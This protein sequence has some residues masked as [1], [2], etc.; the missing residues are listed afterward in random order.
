MKM[1]DSDTIIL[2]P[3]L[4]EESSPLSSFVILTVDNEI[5]SNGTILTVQNEDDSQ[6]LN[7]KSKCNICGIYMKQ[8]RYL[9]SH[10]RE[11]H[12]LAKPFACHKCPVGFFIGCTMKL[13]IQG[14]STQKLMF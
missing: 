4:S 3:E 12:D 2:L 14:V 1:S 11:V 5:D 10:M 6:D 7:S 9:L 8:P 13:V